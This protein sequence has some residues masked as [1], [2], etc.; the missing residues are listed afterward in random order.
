MVDI[1]QN[2]PKVLLVED[3]RSITDALAQAFQK[4]PSHGAH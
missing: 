4:Q 3:D 1:M 2:F